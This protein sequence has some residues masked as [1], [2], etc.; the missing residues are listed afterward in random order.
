MLDAPTLRASG[1]S[2]AAI[3][4]HYDL[5]HDFFALW[6]GDERVYSCALWADGERLDDLARAQRRKLDFF[7]GGVHAAGGRLLDIGCGWGALLQRA[8]EAHGAA[9]GVGLT[10][11]PAQTTYARGR[12]VPGVDIRL[13]SWVDHEP[14]APYDAITCIEATEHLASDRLDPDEK[15]AVYRAFFERCAGWLREGGRL[16]L[17]LICLDN[18]GHAGSRPGRGASSELIRL[19]IFPESMPASLSELVLGWD[20][21]FEVE[22][23]L[24]HHEHYWRTFRA[25]GVRYRA[26]L[27]RARALVGEET[28]RTFSRYFATGDTYFRLREQTLYRAILR[29]RP[30]PKRWVR[31]LRPSDVERSAAAPAAPAGASPG[32]IR[33]HYDVSNAFYR[34]WL[35]PT[36]LYTA[37]L[38]RTAGDAPDDLD[39]AIDRK[40]DFFAAHLVPRAGVRVLDVGCGWGYA[41]R[42]LTT[43]HGAGP[44]VGLT[45]SRA[46]ADRVAAEPIDGAEVR[47]QDWVDHHA[48][49]AYGAIVSFGAFEHFA[50]DGSTSLERV[51]AYRR[52]FGRCFEWLAPGG[53]LG[54][55]TITHDGAPDTDAPLGRGPLGDSVLSLYPESIC[56]HLPEIVLG[57]EPYF[58]VD[59][60]ESDAD[61][62]ARTLRLWLLALRARADEAAAIVGADVV[63][64]YRRYLVSSEVQFRARTLTNTRLVLHRRPRVRW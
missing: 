44:S 57:F 24:D 19:D 53:R 56:P 15:V 34:L 31:P 23:F 54:L 22:R 1:T 58:E 25:W 48:P 6:L 43:R 9:G 51:G 61:G 32:A 64:Q 35:G 10:L 26:A 21:H 28:A 63:R 60:F 14:E 41:L 45:L 4:H 40:V 8:V 20:T 39:A 16:G 11:S 62:F 46:Q 12:E 29:K 49:A 36:M 42:R 13:E 37:G 50:R 27:D 3:A 59:V 55:E 52:F 2:P 17:Q 30:S 7:A 18:V 5:P 33:A 47:V 38:W